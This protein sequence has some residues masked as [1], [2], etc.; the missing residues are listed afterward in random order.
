MLYGAYGKDQAVGDMN[1]A[2]T[3]KF[4]KRT[5]IDCV[6][7][8]MERWFECCHGKYV[9]DLHSPAHEVL[10]MLVNLHIQRIPDAHI[11]ILQD[12]I[13]HINMELDGTGLELFKPNLVPPTIIG[14]SQGN[15]QML[16]FFTEERFNIP[17]FV[18]EMTY[19]GSKEGRLFEIEDY[20]KYGKYVAITM[21]K[22]LLNQYDHEEGSCK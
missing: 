17:T 5:E 21:A 4:Q 3:S 15:S 7:Q 12:F 2:W 14:S 9:M 16:Q 20:H 6:I 8:D 11:Q 19:E 13:T 10:G 22:T 18:M 1:R